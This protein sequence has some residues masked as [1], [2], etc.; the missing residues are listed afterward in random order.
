M[1]RNEKLLL[2]P[3]WF[4]SL[5]FDSFRRLIHLLPSLNTDITSQPGKKQQYHG[6]AS[7]RQD[8]YYCFSPLFSSLVRFSFSRFSTFISSP[9][10]QFFPPLCV[11]QNTPHPQKSQNDSVRVYSRWLHKLFMWMQL[12]TLFQ[13]CA[14]ENIYWKLSDFSAKASAW[15]VSSHKLKYK[16]LP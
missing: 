7:T 5:L 4:S 2:C 13:K 12:R 9:A 3:Y 8:I 6:C 1:E 16:H 15:A 14:W 10:I 11:R